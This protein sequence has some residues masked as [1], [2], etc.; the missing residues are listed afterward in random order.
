[1][2]F[3]QKRALVNWKKNKFRGLFEMATGSGKTFTS[4]KGINYLKKHRLKKEIPYLVIIV[5][6]YKH[7]VEQ[8]YNE[9]VIEKFSP[10]RISGEQGNWKNEIKSISRSLKL[11]RLKD[12]IIITTYNTY[13]SEHF[14][15][16]IDSDRFEKLI[17]AD[18]VHNAGSLSNRNG[19]SQ[20]YDY[21]LGLSATP[22][23]HFDDYGTYIIE[24][25]FN[26]INK[27]TYS[28]SLREA[29]E[30]GSLCGYYYNLNEVKLSEEELSE[31]LSYNRRIGV[32]I[33]KDDEKSKDELK[34]IYIQRS[35]VIKNAQDKYSILNER[36][37][38]LSSDESIK[39]LLIY[40]SPQQID[41]VLEILAEK[42]I[43]AHKFT[44]DED[45]NERKRLIDFF[46]RGDYQVLVAMRCLDE[47]VDIPIVKH[48]IIMSSSGNSREYIQRRGRVLR[49]HKS[50]DYG[51]IDDFI[52]K[53]DISYEGDI[54]DA[55]KKFILQQFRRMLNFAST[56][57]NSTDVKTFIINMAA[58]YKIE[59]PEEYF[60]AR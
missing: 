57:N 32:L 60:D 31:Y 27:P 45:L 23:R 53:R 22:A 9:C 35:N 13:R 52:V 55:E 14:R 12:A 43:R 29:L 20:N 6:P 2:Y 15:T 18:E 50:K 3:Y 41:N 25:Y 17:I 16:T 8:W 48:A 4:L 19:L 46:E 7:L 1:M 58:Q 11:G 56:A 28:F 24:S 40:V 49:R 39:H 38:S 10:K 47:G 51:E 33:N 26:A 36:L 37:D 30:A 59:I 21:R 34:K 42:G 54:L 44:M 5:V